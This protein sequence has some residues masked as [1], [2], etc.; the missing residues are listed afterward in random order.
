[1]A[2]ETFTYSGNVYTAGVAGT[3]DFALISSAAKAIEYLEPSH[4][5]VYISANEGASWTELTRPAQWDFISS[6]TSVRLASGIAAGTW[7]KVQRITPSDGQYV[8]F[9]PSSLLVAEQLNDDTLF[10]TYLNQ[11]RSDQSARAS[12]LAADAVA[13]A[14]VSE[15]AATAASS[16]AGAAA[17]AATQASQD[18]ASALSTAN[19]A[20]SDA[21][22]ALGTANAA[23]SD[24]TAALAAASTAA[25]NAS[26]AVATAN[27]ANSKADQAI[28]AVASALLFLIVASVASIPSSPA[29]GDAI[30]VI[31][32][33][34][35]ESFSPLSGRPAGFVGDPGLSVRLL[36]NSGI[37]SWEWLQ[38]LPADP[39]ARYARNADVG[40][41]I[42]PYDATLL[43]EADV[44][45]T[46]QP[47]DATLLNEADV[48][49]TVQAHDA[50][51]LNEADIGVTVQ[52][53]DATLLNEADVGVTV[54]GYN[55]DLQ[56]IAGLSSAAD[57][58]PY[59]T[60]AGTAAL[61]T[62]TAAARAL[63]DDNSVG[64]MRSTLGVDAAF[65]ITTAET[66]KTL[67]ARERCTVLSAG[68]TL[69][70]PLAPQPGSEVAITVA[71]SFTNTIIARNGSN[72]MSLAEDLTVDRG[73]VTV[74]LYYVDATR[75]WRII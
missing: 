3:T 38:Y 2:A 26:S 24:A 9:Q 52:G 21:S 42:Q 60:G 37:S 20:A 34:G 19:A 12:A 50:T 75:G 7:V 62:L 28:S 68:V 14:A 57:R 70:L 65:T 11:E 31:D 64:N 53:Y 32:S 5:H 43:K 63:L 74:S 69:T 45:V 59:Y 67:A 47:Y 71:G 40:V 39:E 48:G 10:N 13:A 15:A 8:T 27:S 51:L 1:M 44:G 41:T 23:A 35:I 17:Q 30:E 25:S 56:A 54:Q 16:D 6:G 66:S 33:T 72:I 61:A 4:I 18:S 55:A 29:D 36:Y 49:V 73:N 46:V 22:A 58:F